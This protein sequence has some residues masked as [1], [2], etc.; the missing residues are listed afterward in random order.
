MGE[1]NKLFGEKKEPESRQILMQFVKYYK[2]LS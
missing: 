2:H 1:K